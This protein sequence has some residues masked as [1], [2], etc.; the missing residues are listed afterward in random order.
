M[1]Q[2]MEA[3]VLVVER[4]DIFIIRLQSSLLAH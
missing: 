2:Q 4:V 3:L 1:N